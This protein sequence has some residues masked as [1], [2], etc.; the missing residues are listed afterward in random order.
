MVTP[1]VTVAIAI[2]VTVKRVTAT[3]LV[4]IAL[5]TTVML[6]TINGNRGSKA[7]T[8]TDTVHRPYEI[9]PIA[10]Y[11]VPGAHYHISPIR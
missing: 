9:S 6:G 4:F 2:S 5:K 10:R 8:V 3:V 7:A 11:L 1:T